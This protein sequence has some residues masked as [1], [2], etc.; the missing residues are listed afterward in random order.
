M[1]DEKKEEYKFKKDMKTGTLNAPDTDGYNADY[2]HEQDM[3]KVKKLEVCDLGPDT[4][5]SASQKRKNQNTSSFRK[6]KRRKNSTVDAAGGFRGLVVSTLISFCTVRVNR[7]YN[8][9]RR[10]AA[11]QKAQQYRN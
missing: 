10:N 4:E 9:R 7:N 2:E 3:D 8:A 1:A 11:T 5:A 6:T